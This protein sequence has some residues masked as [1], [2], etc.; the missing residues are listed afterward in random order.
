MA[1]AVKQPIIS[2]SGW[3]NILRKVPP[4]AVLYYPGLDYA[5]WYTGTIKDFSGLAVPNNGTIVGAT[6]VRLPSGVRGLDF[7]GDDYVSLGN[8]LNIT[9]GDFSFI[10]WLKKSVSTSV[11]IL[12]KEGVSTGSPG[13]SLYTRASDPYLRFYA[14]DALG[15]TCFTTNFPTN[16]WDGTWRCVGVSWNGATDTLVSYLAGVP[17]DTTVAGVAMGSLTNAYNFEIGR[18]YNDGGAPGSYFVG[19]MAIIQGFNVVLTDA[20]FAQSYAREHHLFNV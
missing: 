20:Q 7:D 19:T 9:T 12:Q 3:R 15:N 5:N 10:I 13:Y 4:G 6:P 17:V 18:N 14:Y 11:V 2:D 1:L 16:I 8:K